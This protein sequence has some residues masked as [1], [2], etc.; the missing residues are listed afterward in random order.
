MS[1]IAL[2]ACLGFAPSEV[3]TVTITSRGNTV[4]QV[5][6]QDVDQT[7]VRALP[8]DAAKLPVLVKVKD[9]PV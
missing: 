8:G 1:V 6:K 4:A 2:L 9:M 3:K 5:L 7:Q